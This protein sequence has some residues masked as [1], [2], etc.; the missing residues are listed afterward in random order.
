MS[1]WDDL[2]NN[3]SSL[4]GGL[5]SMFGGGG[6]ANTFGGGSSGG[7]NLGAIGGALGGLFGGVGG[8]SKPAGQTTTTTTP[9]AGQ[10]PYLLDLF[11]K[12]QQ[13]SNTGGQLNQDQIDA[14]SELGKWA[15]GQNMNPL[16]GVNNPYLQKV[17]GN[18]SGDAMRNL[19]PMINRANAASGS[20]GKGTLR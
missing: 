11:N 15:S 7:S 18:A 8:G 3:S 13:A 2:A 6:F 10:Q 19:Q 9:W 1:F 14:Q 17:I 16:L 20:F 12:S 5:D 4:G